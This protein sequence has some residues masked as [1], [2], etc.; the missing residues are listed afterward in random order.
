MGVVLL[1]Q[2]KGNCFSNDLDLDFGCI[3][4]HI[5]R[6]WHSLPVWNINIQSHSGTA[7]NSTSASV[8]SATSVSKHATCSSI[9][10]L[11][12][13]TGHMRRSHWRHLGEL[14][15]KRNL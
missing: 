14:G 12:R 15:R 4:A 10:K 8:A 13:L 9:Y 2:D 7:S 6:L 3:G 1:L 5:N 11:S